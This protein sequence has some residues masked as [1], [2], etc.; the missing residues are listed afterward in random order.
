M[1]L[2]LAA[3]KHDARPTRIATFNIETFPRHERQVEGAFGEI[4]ALEADAV[5]VEEIIDPA[6]FEREAVARLGS[7][8]QFAHAE[9]MPEGSPYT[10]HIGVLYDRE[11]YAL[12][13]EKL[14][15]DT[16]VDG[17][18]K[19][20]LEVDLRREA[21]DDLVKIFVVHFKSGSAWREIRAK[22]YAALEKIL[23]RAGGGHIVVLGDFNATEESDRDDLFRVAA[24]TRLQWITAPLPCS[25]F[26]DKPDVCDTSRLDHVLAWKP[27]T[28]VARGACALGCS[29]RDSC[30]TYVEDVSDHC[31]IEVLLP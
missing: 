11:V 16:R 4:A 31:P 25:A 28:A 17:R 23:A 13:G 7:H 8:W 26:W 3:C 24:E 1:A 27:G 5:A 20:V 6:R 12:V 10:V 9:T 21:D 30:P 15:D 19:P 2:L 29:A 14:H 22:Q 18:H